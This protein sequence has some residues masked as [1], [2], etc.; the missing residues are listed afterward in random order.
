MEPQDTQ[1]CQSNSEEKE[2]IWSHNPPRFQIILQSYSNQNS[3]VLE[4]KQT[5]GWNRLLEQNRDPRSEPHTL[6]N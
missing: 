2:Q 4:Q 5:Y 6:F 1:N 3:V